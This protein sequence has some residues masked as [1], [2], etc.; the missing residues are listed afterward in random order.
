MTTDGH[1]PYLEAVEAAFG[2]EIDFAQLVKYHRV[3]D[4]G[5]E[6]VEVLK[7]VVS[8]SPVEWLI[9]TSMVER[10]NRTVRMSNRRVIRRTDGFSKRVWRHAAMMLVLVTYYNFC[11]VHLTLKMTPAMAAGLTDH[12]WNRREL[13]DMIVKHGCPGG[14][15][16]PYRCGKSE[17]GSDDVRVRHWGRERAVRED[18]ACANCGSHWMPKD[19]RDA[20]GRQLYRCRDCG[21]RS[22]GQR[23][24][25]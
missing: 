21:Y 19:G 15:R 1:S 5:K 23:V 11:R 6:L 22:V 3:D 14:L 7:N 12:V 20:S 2:G 9:S 8:G 4:D 25:P 13:A 24:E 16:G 10:V 17:G 18:M